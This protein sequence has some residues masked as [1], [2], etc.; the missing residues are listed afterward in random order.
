VTSDNT[1]TN[2]SGATLAVGAAGNYTV[3]GLITNNG[4]TTVAS[5]GVLTGNAGIRNV[6]TLTSSGTVAGG[7]TNTGTVNA[8]GGA[9]NGAIANN[10]GT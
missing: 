6:G 2:A 5:G 8:N 9:I 1:F 3:T 4:T 10:A 7:L